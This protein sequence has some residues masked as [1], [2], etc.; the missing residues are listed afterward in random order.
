M[1]FPWDGACFFAELL[2]AYKLWRSRADKLCALAE[3]WTC[4]IAVISQILITCCSL[5]GVIIVSLQDTHSLLPLWCL[6]LRDRSTLPT[7]PIWN[8]PNKK[9]VVFLPHCEQQTFQEGGRRGHLGKPFS[10]AK[11]ALNCSE[12]LSDDVITSCLSPVKIL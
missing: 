2:F 4:L 11:P 10:L 12:M 7:D 9:G 5:S 1:N 6:H 8:C 3:S